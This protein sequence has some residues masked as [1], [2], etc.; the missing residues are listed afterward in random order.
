AAMSSGG[1][2]TPPPPRRGL[3]MPP[4]DPRVVRLLPERY[5]ELGAKPSDEDIIE[6]LPVP[7]GGQIP[8][9]YTCRSPQGVSRAQLRYRINERGAGGVLPLQ[10]VGAD[11]ETGPSHPT[12]RAVAQP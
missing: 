5:A 8:I 9:A 11:Q 3:Q 2:P 10:P 7:I 12:P 4:E 1:F 6:G